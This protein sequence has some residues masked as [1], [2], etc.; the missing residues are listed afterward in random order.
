M[1]AWIEI[2]VYGT[3]YPFTIVTPFVGAWIEII[4]YELTPEYNEVTP[5]VGAW[6]EIFVVVIS[7][8]WHSSHSLRGSVD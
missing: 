8:I 6:I 4:T 3:I 5:F 1:G 2:Q 7:H